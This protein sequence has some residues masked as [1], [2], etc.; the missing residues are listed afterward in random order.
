MLAELE[1]LFLAEGFAAF[2]LDDLAAKL[3]CSKSTLYTLASSKEQ[4]VVK[5]VTHFFKGAAERI[6]RDTEQAA[7]AAEAVQ[8]YLAGVARELGRATPAFMT[9]VAAFAPARAVY[10][11][12]SRAA[13][14][15]VRSF[16]ADGVRDGVFR[17]VPAP[18][19]GE[20][21]A[22]LIAGIQ[23]G[24]VR[25]RTGVGDADAFAVLAELLLGGVKR[26]ESPPAS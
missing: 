2:T 1:G 10:E 3:R 12:N 26:P 6:D 5:V 23:S 21:T 19:V 20:F 24:T 16:I 17:D 7:D 15:R 11:W 22:L 25:E 4:L 13:A 18:L 8:V 14:D 9:D